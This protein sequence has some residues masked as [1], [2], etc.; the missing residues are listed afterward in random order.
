[1]SDSYP[2]AD[3]LRAV[4]EQ[5]APLLGQFSRAQQTHRRKPGAWLPVEILGHLVDSASNNHQRFVRA[6]FTDY[7]VFPGYDQDAWVRV[8]QYQRYPWDE[9][10]GLW[11][12][13]N[14][15]LAHVMA[16]VPE[17]ERLRERHPHNLH[18][19]AWRLVSEGEAT[20]LDYF[21]RDYV[22]HLRHHLHQLLPDHF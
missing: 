20:T 21:M 19:I 8:Q 22:G 13:Y 4:V 17:T 1:M 15:H 9:L 10:V 3:E 6:Q 7:L 18:Q 5:A 16:A 12:A 11:R 2:P 14:L